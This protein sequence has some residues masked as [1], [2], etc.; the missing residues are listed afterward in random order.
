MA[1]LW[2]YHLTRRRLEHVLPP[3]LERVL[4]VNWRAIVRCGTEAR[5]DDLNRLLWVYRDD[6]FLPHG[7]ATDGHAARQPVYLTSGEETPNA[8]DMLFLVDQASASRDEIK[9]FTRT[10]LIFDGSDHS[11]LHAARTLW[12]SATTDSIPAQY[13][14]EN[15]RGWVKKAEN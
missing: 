10:A 4:K 7:A 14:A 5:M 6:S 15:E 3:L 9:R 1:E 8:P 13:H 2:F 12:K 11:A